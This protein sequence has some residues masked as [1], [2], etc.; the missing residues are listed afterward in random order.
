VSGE[1]ACDEVI[2]WLM[3]A[4]AS[5]DVGYSPQ[6]GFVKYGF[7]HAFRHLLLETPYA[8]AIR[9][10]LAGRGDTDTNA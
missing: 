4:R 5:R 3:D 6:I 7:T 9:E 2:A 1:L 10:T 8:E